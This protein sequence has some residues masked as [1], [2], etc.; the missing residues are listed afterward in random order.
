M[1]IIIN[2]N[3]TNN[4]LSRQELILLVN[5]KG[6]IPSRDEIKEKIA[7]LLNK[8]KELII[9]QK[10]TS[11]F[12]IEEAECFAKI[13]SNKEKLEEIEQEYIKNRNKKEDEKK[14]SD[15]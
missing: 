5:F 6:S 4:L 9:I 3:K 15:E 1:E 7:A 2:S 12:G 8:N 13:Y 10:I 14:S 11:K